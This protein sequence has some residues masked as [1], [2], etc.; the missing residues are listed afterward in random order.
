MKDLAISELELDATGSTEVL[1]VLN[2]TALSN[3]SGVERAMAGMFRACE[4]SQLVGLASASM[5]K[6]A[7]GIVTRNRAVKPPPAYRMFKRLGVMIGT[8]DYAGFHDLKAA[9]QGGKV[10]SV[11][12]A[13]VLSLIRPK[14]IAAAAPTS[15]TTWG[16]KALKVD[17]LWKQGLTG[18]GV[19][20]GHL[21]TGVDG[22]HPAL[23]NAVRSFVQMDALGFAVHPSPAPF[24]S[25]D[26]GT[27]TAGTIAGRMV[28]G[29]SIGVAPGAMLAS[30]MVIEG[31]QVLARVAA[32]LE[33]ALDEGVRVVSMSL[34]IRGFTPFFTRIVEVL[35]SSNVLPVFAIGNEGPATSR[36]PGN[37]AEPLSVG[38]VDKKGLVADFSSSQV[39]QRPNDSLVP[40]IVGPGVSIVSAKPGKA[41]QSMD[42]TS[43]ATPHIA[44]LAALLFEAKKDATV[45][46]V[47]RAIRASCR[48]LDPS[49]TTRAA[50]GLPDAGEA[51]KRLTA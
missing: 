9:S 50:A 23:K 5:R 12:A 7:R 36:S 51:L 32:G 15:A 13:S 17:K 3:P 34:G 46:Q 41:Y 1:V 43:M 38:A 16:I 29:K 20:I 44:G 10:Q 24:D 49:D 4:T 6:N 26:H 18:A 2:D 11:H 37:Y 27:H 39:F 40:D 21:D 14:R 45:D 19:T 31:G 35:R 30:A 25:E 42:G 22:K 28:S 47:E 33:W 48:P 8:V